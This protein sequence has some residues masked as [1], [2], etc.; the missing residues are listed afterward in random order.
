MPAYK[1]VS[2]YEAEATWRNGCLEHPADE[3]YRRVY[4]RRHGMPTK[5]MYV[6]HTCDNAACI[7]DAHH[8]LGTPRDNQQDAISKGRHINQVITPEQM[9]K[10]GSA[11]SKA[12]TG[13]PLSP[14]TR[15]KI[16]AA[17][18]GN[19]IPES[20]RAAARKRMNE[21]NPMKGKHGP[22]HSRFGKLHTE[23]TK[24]KM[25]AAWARRKAQA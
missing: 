1:S 17:N 5:G 25:R 24:A 2:D 18:K 21:A 7:L 16:G 15:K 13:R 9:R 14:E 6:C 11:I 10:R 4:E 8:F 12:L 20:T 3:A 23:E 22:E 19:V